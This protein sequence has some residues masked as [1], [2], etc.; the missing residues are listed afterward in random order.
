M[1]TILIIEDDE[2]TRD[3]LQTILELEGFRP[4][5][6]ADGLSGLALVRAERPA[7]VLCDVMM[8]GLDGFQV[9][10]MMRADPATAEVPLVFLTARGGRADRELGDQAGA[11]GYLAKPASVA[12]VLAVVRQW[13]GEGG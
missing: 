6:A 3:N 13:V 9:L 10:R 7:L 11:Y 4:L 1:K 2:Q 8:P 5:V 12:E